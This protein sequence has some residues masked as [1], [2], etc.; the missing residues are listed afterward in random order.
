MILVMEKFINF[1]YYH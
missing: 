1:F